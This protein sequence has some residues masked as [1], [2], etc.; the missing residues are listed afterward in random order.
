MT[1]ESVHSRACEKLHVKYP[2]IRFLLSL[3]VSEKLP[4]I[5]LRT[6]LPWYYRTRYATERNVLRR[7]RLRR[8]NVFSS[9]W[10]TRGHPRNLPSSP[11]LSSFENDLN[12]HGI[13]RPQMV[14]Y[15]DD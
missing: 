4:S 3:Y 12:L 5:L 2:Y 11:Y 9:P 13:D 10:K 15:S 7:M 1:V 14:G 8:T 6:F